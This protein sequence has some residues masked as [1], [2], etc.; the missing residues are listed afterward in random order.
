MRHPSTGYFLGH[1]GD[2]FKEYPCATH[3]ISLDG[4]SSTNCLLLILSAITKRNRHVSE[5]S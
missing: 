1:I 5:S 4:N 2:R 3:R